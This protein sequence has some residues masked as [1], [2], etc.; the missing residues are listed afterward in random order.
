MK[1]KKTFG[2]L[3]DFVKSLSVG[4]IVASLVGFILQEKQASWLLL[5][6]GILF[7]VTFVSLAILYDRRF[8]NE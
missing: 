2:L 7:F 5:G 4:T 3:I 6:F 8:S 1:Y